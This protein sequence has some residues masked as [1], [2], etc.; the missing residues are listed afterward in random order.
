MA[1]RS[2]HRMD[3]LDR[4]RTKR[5]TNER[6]DGRT[7]EE[8]RLFIRPSVRF[9]LHPRDKQTSVPPFVSQMEF[10]TYCVRCVALHYTAMHLHKTVSC[11][12]ACA[13]RL[14]YKDELRQQMKG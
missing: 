9:K 5:Q 3:A 11:K 6:T 8:T 10:D 1:V 7:D 13:E 12:V 2:P 14:R 4:Q